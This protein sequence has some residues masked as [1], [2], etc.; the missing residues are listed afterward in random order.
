MPSFK[1]SNT[2]ANNSGY[3]NHTLIQKAKIS[4]FWLWRLILIF[5]N[6]IK[7][8]CKIQDHDLAVALFASIFFVISWS[9]CTG[10]ILALAWG[11]LDIIFGI[12]F[13]QQTLKYF[14]RLRSNNN[15]SIVQ[16]IGGDAIQANTVRFSNLVIK[17]YAV[18]STG[19]RT[20]HR[21][22]VQSHISGYI[23]Q[24]IP[25][26]DFAEFLKRAFF[27]IFHF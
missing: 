19:N 15:M 3:V 7:N 2:E 16:D 24:Y 12:H 17:R 18:R 27:I 22:G 10:K 6:C 9:P 1:R 13:L 14:I 5:S 26:A 20:Q 4:R 25:V 21:I 23:A 8:T 11:L